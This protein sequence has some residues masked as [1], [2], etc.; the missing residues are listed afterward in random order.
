[1]LI[2]PAHTDTHAHTPSQGKGESKTQS[3]LHTIVWNVSE[4]SEKWKPGPK[5][6]KFCIEMQ[7]NWNERGL[8]GLEKG[9]VWVVCGWWVACAKW[10]EGTRVGHFKNVNVSESITNRLLLH[11]PRFPSPPEKPAN[12]RRLFAYS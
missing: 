6:K 2:M 8:Q 9:V 1:M 7:A 11:F 4:N 12:C 10:L 5:W 3:I